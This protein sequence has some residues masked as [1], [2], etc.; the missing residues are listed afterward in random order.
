MASNRAQGTKGNC[1]RASRVCPGAASA[2]TWPP[3]TWAHTVTREQ[4]RHDELTFGRLAYRLSRP[5][6]CISHLQRRDGPPAPRKETRGQCRAAAG[7]HSD[8]VG[9]ATDARD[10]VRWDAARPPHGAYIFETQPQVPSAARHTWRLRAT[11]PK[12]PESG[13][14]CTPTGRRCRPAR[15]TRGARRG[16]SS[17]GARGAG[18]ARP[19]GGAISHLGLITV[20]SAN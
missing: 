13:C 14:V 7:Q 17:H 11:R 3:H 5:S 6:T 9:A 20:I 16:V 18:P 8:V 4:G 2:R 19:A 12:S 1:S 15:R 10:A